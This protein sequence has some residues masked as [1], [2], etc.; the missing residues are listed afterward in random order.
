LYA[1]LEF[2]NRPRTKFH[3][4][5]MS[6]SQVIRSKLPASRFFLFIDILSKL[7]QQMLTCSCKFRWDSDQAYFFFMKKSLIPRC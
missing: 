4:D 2:L 3:A 6:D 5:T 7:Q 1:F